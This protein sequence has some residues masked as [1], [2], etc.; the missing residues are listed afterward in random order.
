MDKDDDQKLPIW[1]Q[2]YINELGG[3]DHL[4]HPKEVKRRYFSQ[5]FIHR[6]HSQ[7]SIRSK[8][9]YWV[10]PFLKAAYEK[11]FADVI[12]YPRSADELVR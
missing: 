4:V 7:V 6:P 1:L 3:V 11:K 9:G 2:R 5:D 10:N 12:L 8:D